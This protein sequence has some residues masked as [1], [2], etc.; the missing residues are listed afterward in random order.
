MSGLIDMFKNYVIENEE[1][2]PAEYKEEIEKRL[3]ATAQESQ[4]EAPKVTPG[5]QGTVIS[6]RAELE[7]TFKDNQAFYLGHGTP[8]TEEVIISILNNG[9]KTINPESIRAYGNTLRGLDST[10]IPFGKGT[11]TLFIEHEE[12]LNNWPHKDSK[13]IVII[14]LP[15]EYVLRPAEIGTFAD[16]YEAFY[17]GSNEEGFRLRPEFIKGIYNADTHSFIENENFYQNLDKETQKELFKDVRKGYI[18]S[19]AEHSAVSP[20]ETYTILPLNEEEL[21]QLTIEWY[22]VQLKR[23]RED[24]TFDEKDLDSDLQE[25]AC[26]MTRSAFDGA[27]HSI[28]DDARGD[29][30]ELENTEKGWSIDEDWD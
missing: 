22:K 4:A 21:E 1:D 25:M 2:V 7:A 8:S 23:L 12:L 5:K 15:K 20:T 13:N 29:R 14:S 11:K 19:Y 27:T 9:L 3:S 16:Q 28:K 17:I 30:E 26:N 24:R 10:T 6:D 18:K